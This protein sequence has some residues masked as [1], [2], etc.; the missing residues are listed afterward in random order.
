[1]VG[2]DFAGRNFETD[3]GGG[4]PSAGP[5]FSA[6]S[7]STTFLRFTNISNMEKENREKTNNRIEKKIIEI[8]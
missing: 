8:K 4:S 7:A 1:M 2:E 3:T 6:A 5:P